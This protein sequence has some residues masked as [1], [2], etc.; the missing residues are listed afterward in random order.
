VKILAVSLDYPPTPGGIS[1]HVYELY[2]ALHQLGHDITVL[3]KKATPAQKPDE[4]RDGIRVVALPKRRFGPLYGRTINKHINRLLAQDDYDLVHIHGMR[5]LEFLTPKK[6]PIVYT[7]HTS[8]FLKRLAKGGYRIA[9][10]KSLFKTPDLFLAPSEELLEIPFDI[11]ADK[12]FISNGIVPE[13]FVHNG[14]D[15]RRL[16]AELG[17]AESDKLAIVT[18]RLVEKNGVI[19]L[20]R[21]MEFI[22]NPDLKLLLIGDGPEADDVAA[23]LETHFAGRY[24]MLGAM[25]HHEIVAYYSAADLSILPSLMEATS[26]SCLEAMAANLPIIASNVGGL[27]FLV[28]DGDNGYLSAP[29]DPKDLAAKIETL[30]S[31]D[32]TQKGQAS[33]DLVESKFSWLKIAEQTVTAYRKVL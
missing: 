14:D 4:M 5:P 8:G 11:G 16:R 27:P 17:L 2:A 25:Q 18:R 30:L 9:R 28:H 15:R 21:A 1:A 33:R 12:V 20:A 10:L 31:A 13:R 32:L 7:N 24:H 22:T 3:T 19:H 26:I 29:A 6:I 23:T